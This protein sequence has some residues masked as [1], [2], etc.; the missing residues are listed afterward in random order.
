VLQKGPAFGRVWLMPERI[1]WCH[2]A[3]SWHVWFVWT[4]C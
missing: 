2:G 4:S 1:P 3:G